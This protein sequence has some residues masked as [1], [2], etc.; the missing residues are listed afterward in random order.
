MNDEENLSTIEENEGGDDSL[1]D[2]I[3]STES[4]ERESSESEDRVSS[5]GK[6]VRFFFVPGVKRLEMSSDEK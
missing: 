3:E 4:E 6:L 5:H 2:K 1:N